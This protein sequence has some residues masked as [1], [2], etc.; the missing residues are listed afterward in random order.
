MLKGKI[1]DAN[2]NMAV[3]PGP[4]AGASGLRHTQQGTFIGIV[5]GHGLITD[6]GTL[7]LIPDCMYYIFWSRLR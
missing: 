7:Q 2:F 4:Q 1:T 6:I 5:R 3:R